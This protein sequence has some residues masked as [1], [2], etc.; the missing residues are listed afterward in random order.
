MAQGSQRLSWIVHD[1]QT[2]QCAAEIVEIVKKTDSNTPSHSMVF[3]KV[4]EFAFGK[5]SRD[6]L[7][8]IQV[9]SVEFGAFAADDASPWRQDSR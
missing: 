9:T 5:K 6:L 3:A 2:L 1:D 8:V 4:Q 7:A